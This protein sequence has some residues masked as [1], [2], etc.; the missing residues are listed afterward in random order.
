VLSENKPVTEK[1]LNAGF[2]QYLNKSLLNYQIKERL[3]KNG[4][5]EC[6]VINFCTERKHKIKEMLLRGIGIYIA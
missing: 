5:L 6:S 3:W 4:Q 2:T 1:L